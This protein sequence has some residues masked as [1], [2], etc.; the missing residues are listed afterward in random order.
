MGFEMIDAEK[1][2][3]ELNERIVIWDNP[4]FTVSDVC[5]ITDATPKALEH[6]VDPNRGMVRLLGNH[7][8]PGKGKRRMFSGG[9]VL[10]IK[11][12]FLMNRLGFPQ[13]FSVAMSED[14]LRRARALTIGLSLQ[15]DM[16][17]IT[18][19]MSNGDWAVVPVYAETETVR[20]LPVAVQVLDVDRFVAETKA[21]L[22]AIVQGVDLPDFTVPDRMPEPNWYSPATNG[23]RDWEKDVSGA[24]RYVGLTLDETRILMEHEGI[25]FNGDDLTY[26]A[27]VRNPEWKLILSFRA[28][29]ETARQAL[30]GF[31]D[32]E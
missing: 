4:Q 24:W 6:F 14:V 31:G 18:Y 29:H 21:Q 28:R 8:N 1:H 9:Q 17:I 5:T 2:W 13:K 19:P 12:A 20:P 25:A 30:C 3:N 7:V 10:M 26:F 11:A 23:N 27:G 16:Q 15:T 32:D 22:E